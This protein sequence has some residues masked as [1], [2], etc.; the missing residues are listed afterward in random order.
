MKIFILFRSFFKIHADSFSD[1]FGSLHPH[2]GIDGDKWEGESM[3][4][5]KDVLHFAILP[6]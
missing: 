3:S 1:C 5:Y 4:L 2:T 6:A